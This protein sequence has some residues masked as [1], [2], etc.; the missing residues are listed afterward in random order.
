MLPDVITPVKSP[1]VL[2][3]RSPYKAPSNGL[4]ILRLRGTGS[5]ATLTIGGYAVT[6]G[7]AL[8]LNNNI[9]LTTNALYEFA[10]HVMK[11]ETVL[12]ASA[13][14]LAVFFAPGA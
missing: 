9:A 13:T 5:V 3:R 11:G 14:V 8:L 1:F 4:L 6:E 10:Y 2:L 12:I 7:T